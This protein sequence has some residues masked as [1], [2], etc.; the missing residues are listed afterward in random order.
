MK[1]QPIPTP[2][3]D[4][5]LSIAY[6]HYGHLLATGSA[7]QHITLYTQNGPSCTFKAHDSAVVSVG[8]AHPEFGRLLLSASYDRT[9]KLWTPVGDSW[10]KQTVLSDSH[11][12]LYVAK[13]LPKHLGLKLCT[14]GSDGILRIYEGR[15]W[16]LIEEIPVLE[17]VGEKHLQSDFDIDWC[18]RE[19]KAVVSALDQAFIYSRDNNSE[20]PNEPSKL[21]KIGTLDGH[22]GLIRS[23]AWAPSMGREWELIATACKDGWVRIFRDGELVGKF[24]GEGEVWKVEWNKTG[25]VL[26][27]SGDDGLIRLYK[28]DYAGKWSCMSVISAE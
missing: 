28:A 6:D 23:V 2:H 17:N 27:S 12:P 16:L 11:G 21:V 8:F 5:I 20:V 1:L 18:G 7:D 19:E 25:T 14:L 9:C 10:V 4:L 15:D 26:S 22:G 3:E 13:F 24:S